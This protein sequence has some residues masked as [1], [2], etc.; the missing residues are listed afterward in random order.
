[1]D[2]PLMPVVDASVVVDWVAP[3]ADPHGPAGLALQELAGRLRGL[4]IVRT[5]G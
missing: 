2:R 5:I 1:M 4:R 3:H